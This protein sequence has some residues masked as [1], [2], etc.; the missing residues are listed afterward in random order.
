MRGR[1]S[2]L[3]GRRA[4][5]CVFL[6][7]CLLE[8]ER[9]AGRLVRSGAASPLLLLQLCS[10]PAEKRGRGSARGQRSYSRG[11]LRWRD[12][13]RGGGPHDRTRWDSKKKSEEGRES[14]SSSSSC[15]RWDFS[16]RF[17][18]GPAHVCM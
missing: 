16:F 8:Q 18:V 6:Y 3:A 9:W 1:R 13:R 15:S 17:Y 12:W 2:S 7:I 10:R 11:K 5:W 4:G 14:S